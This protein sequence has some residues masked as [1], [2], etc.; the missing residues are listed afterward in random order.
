MHPQKTRQY[1]VGQPVV[2]DI[3]GRIYGSVITD[4]AFV[5]QDGSTRVFLLGDKT[6]IDVRFLE[7]V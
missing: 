5:G 2:V 1:K 7:V 4:G 3:N 6:S